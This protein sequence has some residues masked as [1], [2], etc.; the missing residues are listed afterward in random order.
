MSTPTT[1]E[2]LARECLWH[3][4]AAMERVGW[5]QP[6]LLLAVFAREGATS[7]AALVAM[8][9]LPGW[10]RAL[11]KGED[12]QQ[13]L[14]IMAQV[15][16]TAPPELKAEAVSSLGFYGLALVSEAWMLRPGPDGR[17]TDEAIKHSEDH[18]IHDHPDRVEARLIHLSAVDGTEVM[19]THERDG[20]A[21]LIDTPD[22]A[23]PE[24]M[25]ELVQVIL[26]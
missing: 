7:G 21:E 22:G 20:I 17:L 25:A 2:A 9:S 10:Q 1:P 15:Y 3:V 11:D 14:W 8:T 13:V 4:D 26:S 24:L 18:T 5:D 6:P 12:M 23:I 16:R 19:L